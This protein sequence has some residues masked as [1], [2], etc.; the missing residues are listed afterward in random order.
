MP[1]FIK[2]LDG[3]EALWQKIIDTHEEIIIHS[4]ANNDV[5]AAQLHKWISK[6]R[7]LDLI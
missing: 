3:V 2:G 6:C 7:S 1:A 4:K 5:L